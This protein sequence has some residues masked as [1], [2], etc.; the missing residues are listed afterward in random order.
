MIETRLRKSA[1]AKGQ[2]T[3]QPNQKHSADCSCQRLGRLL[4]GRLDW[5][6]QSVCERVDGAPVPHG[7]SVQGEGMMLVMNG[8]GCVIRLMKDRHN[9]SSHFKREVW[10]GT[11]LPA[12]RHSRFDVLQHVL[13]A[14]RV[15][16]E[17]DMRQV[18]T[19]TS[20]R[21]LSLTQSAG[22]TSTTCSACRTAGSLCLDV[23]SPPVYIRCSIHPRLRSLSLRPPPLP[24]QKR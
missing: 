11:Q 6:A 14:Q 3:T 19:A 7:T 22:C 23:L 17:Q 24:A 1:G 9:K 18:S 15:Q 5:V 10:C 20:R 16:E 12:A 4:N 21:L 13:D 8:R 2:A